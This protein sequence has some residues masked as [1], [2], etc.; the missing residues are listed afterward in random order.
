MREE[1]DPA[2]VLIKSNP[3]TSYK[4]VEK[5]PRSSKYRG[6]S[7]NGTKWQVKSLLQAN[8]QTQFNAKLFV[9]VQVFSNYTKRFRGQITNE[10]LGAR[11]YDKRTIQANGLTA[12]TN[13]SYT[14]KQLERMMQT[15]DDVH[16][17]D[18]DE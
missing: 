5:C 3:K 14:K 15:E 17:S 16:E 11:I 10:L 6:V 7:K 9:Q 18:L 4:G 1:R 13:F 12:K 2:K 8:S